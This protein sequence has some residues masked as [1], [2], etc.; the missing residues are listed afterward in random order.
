MRKS[1]IRTAGGGGLLVRLRWNLFVPTDVVSFLLRAAGCMTCAWTVWRPFFVL[2][3]ALLGTALLARDPA[4][5]P[6]DSRTTSGMQESPVDFQREILPLL[7]DR[8]FPCHGPDE[9]AR[10]RTGGLRLDSYAGAT[11]DLGG[12]AAI[13]PGDPDASEVILRMTEPHPSDRMPPPKSKLVVSDAEIEIIR[14]WISEGANYEQHWAFQPRAESP[15]PQVQ[16]SQQVKNPIDAFVLADLEAHGLDLAPTADREHLLRR[17]SFDLTGLPPD[18]DTMDRFLDEKERV[19]Y[20]E[21]VDTLLAS[22]HFGERMAADWMDVARYADTYGYQN[23]AARDVWPW[24]DWVIRAFNQNLPY[25]QFLTWQLAGDLLPNPTRDQRLATTFNRL[26]RQTN[27]G[28]SVEEEYRVEYVADRVHTFGSAFLGLTLE[29]ARCHDHKYDPI[30][31]REYFELFAF[32]DDIDESGL[33]PH[34]NRSVPTPALTLSTPEEDRQLAQLQTTVRDLERRYANS[35][36]SAYK[37]F[38]EDQA[39][40][41][42]GAKSTADLDLNMGCVGHFA[43]N[44]ISDTTVPNLVQADRSGQTFDYPATVDGVSGQGLR[45]SGENGV[46]FPQVGEFRRFDAFSFSLWVQLPE[47]YD[48]AV[49]MHRSRA[50]TDSGSRG[51]QLILEQGRLSFSLIHFWPGNALRVRSLCPLPTNRWIHL[52]V[53]YDGSSRAEGVRL[54]VDGKPMAVEIVRDQLTRTIQGGSHVLTIGQRFRDRGFK[55]GQVD[56]VRVYARSLCSSEVRRLFDGRVGQLD[57]QFFETRLWE[58]GVALREELWQARKEWALMIDSIAQIMTMEE[59]S[60]PRQAYVLARGSYANRLEEV[61]P[62]TPAVLPLLRKKGP[63]ANRLDLANWLA[64]ADHPL[65]ARVA[66]NRFWQMLFGVGL[67]RTHENFGRQ[68]EAPTHPEL[69]DWLAGEFVRSGWNVKALL[70]LIVMSSTYRQQSKYVQQETVELRPFAFG[71]GR[72]KRLSSEMVR[73]QAL[74]ASGLLKERLGGPSVKPYQPAG[75]WKEKSGAVYQ[76]S[77][78][79]DLYRRSLYTYW[80]RTS[81]PPSMMIFD[82]AKR[83]VCVV[84]RQYTNTPLQA[85][86]VMNDVQYLEASRKLAEKVS[87]EFPGDLQAQLHSGFRLLTGRRP[88]DSEYRHLVRLFE[89]QWS[90]YRQNPAAATAF[91]SIG[92]SAVGESHEPARLAALSVVVSTMMNSDASLTLR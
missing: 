49:L 33:Y 85:L 40:S 52:A 23:D 79:P 32:F 55:N 83:D 88:T 16:N 58:D 43:L 65:V 82:A 42:E 7:S 13:V 2:G 19:S 44:S 72:S 8:C 21:L 35:A 46:K 14:R 18:L 36:Q 71:R 48:R 76:Q 91:L 86:V 39:T 12:Y 60:Q 3:A 25:D 37:K 11:A 50:W 81:P 90:D 56:E 30:R 22:A 61:Q 29:C 24:R 27:E 78:G 28:G 53:T 68:G 73:D 5:K 17:I 10:T 74:A 70:R 57:Q 4:S 66:V 9:K 51:Y 41:P 69:L 26:H 80:K 6:I 84:R 1:P 54:Y 59:M 45:L 92:E 67:V 64:D 62:E 15:V 75:L 89:D 34:F 87:N 31:Q 47:V 63:V 77:E 38:N 20:S